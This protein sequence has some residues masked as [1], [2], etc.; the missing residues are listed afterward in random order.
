MA[1]FGSQPKFEFLIT[2]E[3]TV[4]LQER[5]ITELNELNSPGKEQIARLL[6]GYLYRA[7][8]TDD[9]LLPQ[10]AK[11]IGVTCN[12]YKHVVNNLSKSLAEA[13]RTI[14]ELQASREMYQKVILKQEDTINNFSDRIDA[15]QH[16]N[17]KFKRLVRKLRLRNKKLS[18]ENEKAL[19]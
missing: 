2:K 18:D 5:V 9:E 12:Q 10:I 11:R 19:F 15:L 17:S 6:T 8:I 4:E 1:Q 7:Y 3:D 16:R 13:N 14:A